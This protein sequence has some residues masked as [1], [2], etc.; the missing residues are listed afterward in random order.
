MEKLLVVALICMFSSISCCGA[1]AHHKTCCMGK[2]ANHIMHEETAQAVVYTCPMHPEVHQT[3]PGSCPKC[4]M[5][6]QKG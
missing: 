1:K 6:L 5:A 2:E 3:N 4:G